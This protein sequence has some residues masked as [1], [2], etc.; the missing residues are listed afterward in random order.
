[1]GLKQKKKQLYGHASLAGSHYKVTV[2]CFIHNV[3]RYRLA[4]ISSLSLK[5]CPDG[6]NNHVMIKVTNSLPHFDAWC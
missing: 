5:R 2:V 6:T 1:M 3:F 4:E